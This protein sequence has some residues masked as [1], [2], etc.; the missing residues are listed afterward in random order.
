M[1][2][3]S[4]GCMAALLFGVVSCA[5]ESTTI[6]V[7]TVPDTLLLSPEALAL[8]VGDTASVSVTAF[9]IFGYPTSADV[10]WES[11][12]PSIAAISSDGLVTAVGAG[13]TRLYAIS[14]HTVSQLAVVVAEPP[15][16]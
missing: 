12:S 14:S 15:A 8:Q 16:G 3:T 2:R 5:P 6:P 7:T 13:A 10:T 9:T 4:A 11:G 1:T